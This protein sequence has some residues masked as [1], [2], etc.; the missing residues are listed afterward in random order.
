[1][2]RTRPIGD[3]ER[4]IRHRW[5]RMPFANCRQIAVAGAVVAQRMREPT[6]MLEAVI[7]PALKFRDR[8]RG[9]KL[10]C[11]AQGVASHIVALAPF[12]QNSKAC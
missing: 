4:A 6:L 2:R 7:V 1:M 3:R 12:S 10:C 5:R 9:K 11:T 8:M